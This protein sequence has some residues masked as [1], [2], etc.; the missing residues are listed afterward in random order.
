MNVWFLGGA[1][2]KTAEALMTGMPRLAAWRA[3]VAAIGHGR[4]SEMAPAKALAVAKAAEPA[5][6]S[7]HDAADP[8]GLSPGASVRVMADDYGR[9]PIDGTLVAANAAEVVL[10]REDAAVGRVHVHFPRA[11][12]LVVG[13]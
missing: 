1:V 7:G 13:V 3:R 2:P 11:G 4:R 5:A 6:A 8:L 12:Y 10:A 9:D